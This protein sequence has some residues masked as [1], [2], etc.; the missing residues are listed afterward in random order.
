[1]RSKVLSHL[2]SLPMALGS[3]FDYTE[4]L[5]QLKMKTFQYET[6]QCH[7]CGTCDPARRYF[8][9]EGGWVCKSCKRK[10]ES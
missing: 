8:E 9:C 7:V 6:K 3:R 4:D 1:M 5:K 2:M 10:D